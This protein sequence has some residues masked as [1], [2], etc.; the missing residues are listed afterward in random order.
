MKP[1]GNVHRLS[2][3]DCWQ[4]Q[5]KIKSSLVQKIKNITSDI[6]SV[7]E[8]MHAELTESSLANQPPKLLEDGSAVSALNVFKAELDQMRRILWFYIEEAAGRRAIQTDEEHLYTRLQ[9]ANDLLRTMAPRTS[10]PVPAQGG[11]QPSISFF[12]RL[13]VVIDTY[14]EKKPVGQAKA[15][16]SGR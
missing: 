7:Q 11:T 13:D 5:S 8:E 4:N 16:K 10:N 2:S 12:E 14:M 15:A 1:T 9:R 6:H 3:I